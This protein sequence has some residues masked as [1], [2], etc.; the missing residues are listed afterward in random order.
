MEKNQTRV[1]NRS[2][3][4]VV[5][6]IPNLGIRRSI[7]AGQ[8]IIVPKS[9]IEAL[10]FTEGGL[11][12]IRNYLFLEDEETLDELGVHR[13][14]EYYMDE[15]K[16]IDLLKNKSLDEFKDALDFAPDGVK[17]MIRDL[18]VSLPLNDY[19]KRKALK[20]QRDFDVDAAIDM[21]QAQKA[22]TGVEE[23]PQVRRTAASTTPGRRTKKATTTK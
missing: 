11:E 4:T 5:Y 10:S 1:V 17:D 13:E 19:A 3:G 22:E 2:S 12:L 18:A 14:P 20:D 21:D 9:E 7:A 6:L 23:A 8:S 15:K 16:V